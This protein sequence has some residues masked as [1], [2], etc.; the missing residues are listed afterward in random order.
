MG[1]FF[2]F[3]MHSM[4][5]GVCVCV[6]SLEMQRYPDILGQFW[7]GRVA[8]G[9]LWSCRAPVGTSLEGRVAIG[10]LWRCRTIQEQGAMMAHSGGKSVLTCREARLTRITIEQL[11][12]L[13]HQ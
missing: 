10:Q 9:H 1:S 8:I 2:N 5:R 6:T 11:W 13:E 7:R 12:R 3:L 4:C